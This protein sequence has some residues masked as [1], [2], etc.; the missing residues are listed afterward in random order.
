MVA[1]PRRRSPQHSP[2]W[3]AQ[4]AGD[5]ATDELATWLQAGGPGES[6]VPRLLS[7]LVVQRSMGEQDPTD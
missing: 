6:P 2:V 1:R 7:G 5:T 4:L 3:F